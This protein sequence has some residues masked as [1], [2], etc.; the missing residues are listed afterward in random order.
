MSQ[1]AES[2]LLDTLLHALTAIPLCDYQHYML[3]DHGNTSTEAELTYANLDRR[4]EGFRAN[5]TI[6]LSLR[7]PAAVIG[8]FSPILLCI[9]SQSGLT[10]TGDAVFVERDAAFGGEMPAPVP[11]GTYT[12][13]QEHLSSGVTATRIYFNTENAEI[14]RMQI[15]TLLQK[16]T[17]EVQEHSSVSVNAAMLR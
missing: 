12:T 2:Q 6:M 4:P 14:L 13:Q 8:K 16:A 3:H 7:E 17:K 9:L 15:K 11:V 5:H 1:D 10:H